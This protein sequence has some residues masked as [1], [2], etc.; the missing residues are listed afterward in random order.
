MVLV[1]PDAIEYAWKQI[2]RS[3]KGCTQRGLHTKWATHKKSP[4][5]SFK[6]SWVSS[7][8]EVKRLVQICYLSPLSS[9][10]LPL[11]SLSCFCSISEYIHNWSKQL[12]WSYIDMFFFNRMLNEMPR[13]KTRR[14]E[15]KTED[16]QKL[17]KKTIALALCSPFVRPFL[18]NVRPIVRASAVRPSVC[19]LVHP[20]IRSSIRPCIHPPVRCVSRASTC[21][22][23]RSS[24]HSCP[25]A[26][27][28][29]SRIRM[30]S[31]T[32][33]EHNFNSWA[34]FFLYRGMEGRCIAKLSVQAAPHHWEANCLRNRI[35]HGKIWFSFME[36]IRECF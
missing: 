25:S 14:S 27:Y 28:M 20:F 15:G 31:D 22:S 2:M 34:R 4:K 13:I 30:R 11:S 18:V 35:S 1:L 32:K 17:V 33:S 10:L 24:V 7:L 5:Y 9:F 3:R 29:G 12:K 23:V 16:V 21:S 6:K 19:S 36:R 26:I 8:F